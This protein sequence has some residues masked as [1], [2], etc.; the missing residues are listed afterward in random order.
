MISHSFISRAAKLSRDFIY[1]L[2]GGVNPVNITATPQASGVLWHSNS[3][4]VVVGE[5]INVSA[6]G[7]MTLYSTPRFE[8][9]AGG[10]PNFS[11]Y[12]YMPDQWL[13]KCDGQNYDSERDLQRSL[14]TENYN[15]NGV[16]LTY[17]ATSYDTQYDKIFGEDGDRR[18]IRK[19]LVQSW[20]QLQQEDKMWTKFAMMGIDNFVIYVSK[21]HFRDAAT[22]GDALIKGNLGVDT[23]SKIVPKTGDVIKSNFNN[24]FY[25]ITNVKEEAW[26]P[27]LSKSYIWE[28]NVKPFIDRHIL[29][30][31]DT[32]ASME[33]VSAYTN[34]QDIFN[35]KDDLASKISAIDY[36]PKVCDRPSRDPFNGW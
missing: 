23:F 6:I 9:Y 7:V 1:S 29:L 34:K 10:I 33:S 11:D 27:L 36:Q 25:E 24:Y 16:E 32:A 4:T 21:D 35:I 31:A 8:I 12:S 28:L 5:I 17:Y 3:S 19:F 2:F 22:Y 13:R 20:F 14:V 15:L 30:S 26:M 18:F